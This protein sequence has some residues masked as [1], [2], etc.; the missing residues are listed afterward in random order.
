MSCFSFLYQSPSLSLSTTF[1]VVL[2]NI[3]E[4]LLINPYTNVI[5]FGTSTFIIRIDLKESC[6]PDC[7][8]VSSV[9]P[10]YENV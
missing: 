9:V 3:D 5:V 2:S 1:Q 7:W 8:K 4:V 6:L 10:V